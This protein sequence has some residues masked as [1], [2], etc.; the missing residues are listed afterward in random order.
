MP[1]LFRVLQRLCLALEPLVADAAAQREVGGVCEAARLVHLL[2]KRLHGRRDLQVREFYCHL[3][4]VQLAA[5]RSRY[6]GVLFVSA[7]TQN[8]LHATR[9]AQI[10]TTIDSMRAAV[11]TAQTSAQ[12]SAH[13]PP[14]DI[15]ARA[16]H[17]LLRDV[18]ARSPPVWSAEL[19]ADAAGQSWQG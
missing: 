9:S 6:R 8:L 2:H 12:Q 18:E 16:N 11:A 3:T 14:P 13:T 5:Q 19:T 7:D 10:V 1:R 4:A 15:I 17:R